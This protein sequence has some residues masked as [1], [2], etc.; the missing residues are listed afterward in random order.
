VWRD[1]SEGNNS[2]AC[3]QIPGFLAKRLA[4]RFGLSRP[5]AA[6]VVEQ[7]DGERAVR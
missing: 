4:R 2:G 6:V 1:N 5:F 7:A 3:L